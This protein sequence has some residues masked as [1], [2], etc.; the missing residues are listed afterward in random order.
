MPLNLKARALHPVFCQ[1]DDA[2]E[3]FRDVTFRGV[4]VDFLI[5]STASVAIPISTLSKK[6]I[7]TKNSPI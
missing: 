6:Q 4:I 3:S 5:N 7:Q 1:A 2:Y